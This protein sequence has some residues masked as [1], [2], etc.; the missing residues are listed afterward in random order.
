MAVTGYAHTALP[1]SG[2]VSRNCPCAGGRGEDHTWN[3]GAHSSLGAAPDKPDRVLRAPTT[4]PPRSGCHGTK[5]LS[6]QA[7]V[8]PR[9]KGSGVW[10]LGSRA[11]GPGWPH[12]RPPHLTPCSRPLLRPHPPARRG[13]GG[14]GPAPACHPAGL[15]DTGPRGEACLAPQGRGPEAGAGTRWGPGRAADAQAGRGPV[16]LRRR[17]SGAAVVC[18]AVTAPPCTPHT[19]PCQTRSRVSPGKCASHTVRGRTCP[20]GRLTRAAAFCALPAHR[21]SQGGHHSGAGGLPAGRGRPWGGEEP[22]Q[23]ARGQGG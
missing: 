18:P 10:G 12:P 1:E 17:G 9:R 6:R 19:G 8:R 3:A 11:W 20:V 14:L 15:G 7:A 5:R 21:P 13:H 2:G 16:P 4:R 22:P 23:E